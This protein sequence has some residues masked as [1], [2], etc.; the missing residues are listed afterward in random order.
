MHAQSESAPLRCNSSF[1]YS[2]FICFSYDYFCLDLF[3]YS[4]FTHIVASIYFTKRIRMSNEKYAELVL[5]AFICLQF[6]NV[7]GTL[8]AH[9]FSQNIQHRCHL[10]FI[11]RHLFIS[12]ISF[13]SLT[14]FMCSSEAAGDCVP[15]F[16]SAAK[17]FCHF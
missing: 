8:I 5:F 6:A 1:C 4:F 14:F 7:W 13:L 16:A 11:A 2:I 10:E 12:C 9:V 3:I 15:S 17:Y